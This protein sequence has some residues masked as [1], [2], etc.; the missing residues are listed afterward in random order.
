[1]LG[2]AVA[3]RLFMLGEWSLW[4]DE[5]G[6]IYY[7]LRLEKA[8]PSYFPLF[9]AT[10]HGVFRLTGVSVLAGRLLC[11]AL[12][13]GSIVL[14]YACFRKL[15]SGPVAL[16]AALFLTINL[17]HLFW[18]QSIRYY[19]MTL[20]FQ[21]LSVYWFLVGFERG[22]SGALLLSNVAFA[23]A[24]LTHFTAVLLAPVYVA[25]LALV[26]WRRD[27]EGAYGLRSYLVF[28]LPFLTMLGMLAER[29]L[30]AQRVLSG[31]GYPSARDPL[32][33]L[34][35][36]LAYFGVP[37]IGLGLLAPVVAR[38]VPKRILHFLLIAGT[39]PIL[40]LIVIAQ[41]NLLH[42]AWYYVFISLV[43]L[44]VLAAICLVSLYQSDRRLAS[45]LLGSAAVLYYAV[46]LV[47]YY[48]TM[49]GDRPRWQEATAFLRQQANVTATQEEPAVFATV[50]TIIA[51]YLGV[52]PAQ[53]MEHPR[54]HALPESPPVLDVHAEQWYLVEAGQVSGE[55]ASWFAAHCTLVKQFEAQ[56]GPVDRSVL[57][58]YCPP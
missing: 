25:Y 38:Q 36:V 22:R 31:L 6:S 44:A 39:L 7:S 2:I 34:L 46:F 24:L 55:Y 21:L 49:H 10:L 54:V 43:A 45:A 33:L 17:G 28:G 26:L 4:E 48:T 23:C 58:Y 14:T 18:S 47:G 56:T 51:Y 42:V 35:T 19:M 50:P 30:Q 1:V 16:V 15:L 27:S 57:V 52:G 41:L 12:G 20:D 3:L 13:M 29:F 37:V 11:A 40:E 9:F 8:F 5:V 32:H 53:T